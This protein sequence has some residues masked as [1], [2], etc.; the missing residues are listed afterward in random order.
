[1]SPYPSN[2]RWVPMGL[3]LEDRREIKAALHE[4][5]TDVKAMRSEHDREDGQ[6]VAEAAAEVALDRKK[7]TKRE[8]M[9][10]IG[11]ATFSAVLALGVGVIVSLI[12]GG[13][14]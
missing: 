3:Y 11:L 1:M 2:D 6:E 10:D 12:T 5:A 14:T 8:V 9:R 4:I 7:R 13:P